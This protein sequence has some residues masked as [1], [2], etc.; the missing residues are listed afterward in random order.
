M[1]ARINP[2]GI[3]SLTEGDAHLIRNAGGAIT[4]DA[5]R[6]PAISQ[7]LLGTEEII[8]IH[9]NDCGMRTFGSGCRPCAPTTSQGHLGLGE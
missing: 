4:E 9:H 6:S 2:Y 1:D 7:R 3:F 8:L 5:I